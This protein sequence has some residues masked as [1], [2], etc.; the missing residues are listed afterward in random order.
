MNILFIAH[1]F[2]PTQNSGVFRNAAFARHLPGF[3]IFP[4]VVCASD[5]IRT[6]TYR[7]AESW[8]DEPGWLDVT[9][10]PWGLI[11][12][13]AS[14]GTGYRILRRLPFGASIATRNHRTH[15]LNR[16]QPA[17]EELVRKHKPDLIYASAP[18]IETIVLADSVARHTGLPM[19]LDLRDPLAYNPWIRYRHR[20][21]FRIE[22]RLEADILN[23]AAAVIANTPTAARLLVEQLRVEPSRVRVLPNGYDDDDFRAAEGARPPDAQRF[24]IVYTGLLSTEKPG[25]P[26]LRNAI[27]RSLGFDYWPME[28]DTST[29]SPQ[30]FLAALQSLLD[31]RHALR[32]KVEAVFA[33]SFHDDMHDLF[34]AFHYPGAL[35]VLAPVPR[36]EAAAMLVQ[37]DLCLLLQFDVRLHGADFCPF[38]PGKL[39]DYLRSGTP[40][41]APMNCPDAAQIIREFDA[42]TV[43]PPR[44]VPAIKD[45]LLRAITRWENEG[46]RNRALRTGCERFERRALTRELATIMNEV[47][48]RPA[49]SQ[50][51]T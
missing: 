36:R 28:L 5:D 14:W 21:D 46:P 19:V 39:Y 12:A 17:A 47:A 50:I 31:E 25:K 41:L 10:L 45:A 32:S 37:S 30:W 35:R 7:R 44:D 22:A 15:V 27:K 38:V 20:V 11:E 48:N 6:L 3:G 33:G 24:R 16:I 49:P 23:R 8:K 9:R 4:A 42:G 40:I 13:P 1:G 26:G 51:S 43:I 2:P 29:R 18:P 34:R